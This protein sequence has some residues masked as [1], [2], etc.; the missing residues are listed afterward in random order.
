MTFEGM[1]DYDEL[2]GETPR[3]RTFHDVVYNEDGNV[4]EPVSILDD[5]GESSDVSA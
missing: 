2:D 3:F 4:L 1:T 5:P